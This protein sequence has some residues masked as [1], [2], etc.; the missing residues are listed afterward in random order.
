MAGLGDTIF[1]FT[2]LHITNSDHH[3]WQIEKVYKYKKDQN[4]PC[5]YLMTD[6]LATI[7]LGVISK[8]LEDVNDKS[9]FEIIAFWAPLLLLHL[10]GPDTI[11]AYSLED[12]KY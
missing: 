3:F 9:P 12:N 2:K 8:N 7:A 6:F 5:A 11:T 10:G 1:G 4:C